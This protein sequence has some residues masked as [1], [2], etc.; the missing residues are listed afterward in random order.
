MDDNRLLANTSGRQEPK[1][2][3]QTVRNSAELNTHLRPSIPQNLGGPAVITQ[4]TIHDE[5]LTALVLGASL[6]TR[7]HVKNT[8]IGSVKTPTQLK[9]LRR[10]SSSSA[11]VAII[12]ALLSLLDFFAHPNTAAKN[13]INPFFFPRMTTRLAS[14][15][16]PPLAS[17]KSCASG[18]IAD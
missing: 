18:K 10:L 11:L 2:A 1:D 6:R 14:V 16:S 8:S 15:S 7:G 3:R 17:S 4:T 13:S 9:P 12:I 5:P